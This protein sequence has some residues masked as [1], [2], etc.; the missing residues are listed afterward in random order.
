M[1]QV[2]IR[3]PI[4]RVWA[5]ITRTDTPIAAFFNSRMT[6]GRQGLTPGSK[7]AMRTPNGRNTGVVGVI[8]ECVPP[9]RLS[10]TFRFTSMNDPECTVCY[11]LRAVSEGTEFTMVIDNLPVGTKTAKQ[12]VQGGTLITRTLKAVLET[13]RPSLGVRCLFLLF[14][15]IPMPKA[16]RSEHWPV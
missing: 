6:L 3:A 5:E 10:H 7:L 8:L 11:E 13:G 1:F 16:T 2:V 9:N 14:K 12:M 4:E 15:V